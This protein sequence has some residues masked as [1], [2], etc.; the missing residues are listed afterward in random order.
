[1]FSFLNFYLFIWLHA[2]SSFFKFYF[3]FK[4]Y[5]IV[6]SSFLDKETKF[7]RSNLLS[8]IQNVSVKVQCFFLNFQ[9]E[10]LSFLKPPWE[11]AI[12]L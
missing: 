1:M 4:L 7:Q 10:T 2:E 3:I 11:R 9:P 5:N 6:M 8:N 12:F